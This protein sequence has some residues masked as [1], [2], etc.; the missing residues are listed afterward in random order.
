MMVLGSKHVGV[1][2]DVVFYLLLLTT[3]QAGVYFNGTGARK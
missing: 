3:A 2:K 1:I